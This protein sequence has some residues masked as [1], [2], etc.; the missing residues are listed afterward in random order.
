MHMAPMNHSLAL[1]IGRDIG[2]F[3][4]L[5]ITA[6]CI[7]IA[8]NQLRDHPLPLRYASKAE[9]LDEVVATLGDTQ[10]DPLRSGDSPRA[11]VRRISLDEFRKLAADQKAIVV[12]ARAEIYYRL[13]HIPGA[14]PL[15]RNEFD[16]YYQKYLTVLD[17]NKNQFVLIYCDGHS[18]KDSELVANAL[19]RL[20]YTK[21]AIFGG[22]WYSWTEHGLPQERL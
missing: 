22:G 15:P 2:G 3:V 14:L 12:D 4:I 18:C 21:L 7:G 13:A 10:T 6:L 8:L 9:R 5:S 20:G 1:K 16:K 11:D 17:A 19:S